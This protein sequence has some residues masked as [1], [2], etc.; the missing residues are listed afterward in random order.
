VLALRDGKIPPTINYQVKDPLCDLNYTPNVMV[1][2]TVN[3][4]LNI[5]VGFGGQNAALLFKKWTGQ[6]A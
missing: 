4:A 2:H 3:Y 5:N 6:H 1:A